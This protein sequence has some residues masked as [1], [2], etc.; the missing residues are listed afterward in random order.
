MEQCKAA[1]EGRLPAFLIIVTGI[2]RE[3]RDRIEHRYNR[4]Y[5]ISLTDDVYRSRAEGKAI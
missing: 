5:A 1:L 2:S 4:E 3:R